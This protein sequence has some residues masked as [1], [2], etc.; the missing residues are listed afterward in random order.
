MQ[1]FG[2]PVGRHEYVAG[3][4]SRWMIPLVCAASSAPAIWMARSRR[5]SI[6][7]GR[8][9][10]RSQGLAFEKLPHDE[11]LAFEFT[12]VVNRADILKAQSRGGARFALEAVE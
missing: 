1:N 8:P 6:S 12:D 4:I 3:L 11:R 7:S 10:M 5:S 2:V 9:A